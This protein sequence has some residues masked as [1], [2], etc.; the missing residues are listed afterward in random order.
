MKWY[1]NILILLFLPAGILH[2]QQ[3]T[4]N[5]DILF[6]ST[7]MKLAEMLEVV[8]DSTGYEFSFNPRKVPVDSTFLLPDLSLH[9]DEFLNLLEGY[10][11]NAEISGQHVILKRSRVMKAA[12]PSYFTLN[13]TLSDSASGEALIGASVIVTET[14][15]G[16]VTNGY[17]FFSLTLEK[18]KHEIMVSYVGYES[19]RESINLVSDMNIRR[20]L[21]QIKTELEEVE[22]VS[23]EFDRI[24]EVAGQGK[25]EMPVVSVRKMPG[26]LGETDVIK[27]LQSLPGISF[28]SDGSTIFHVRGGARDQNLLMIDE[29][30]VYNPAHLLGLFSVFTPDALNSINVYKGDMPAMYGGRLSSVID[31][32]MKEGNRNKLSFSGNTGPIA[33]T[34]NLEAPFLKKKGSFYLSGRRSHLKWIFT[35]SSPGLEELHFTDFNLKTN[36]RF[37]E[38]NRLYISFYSGIDKFRNR[39]RIL[40]SSGIS[41]FN[42]AGNIRWNTV[43]RNRIFINT[44]LIYSEYDYN[45]YTSY[46][47]NYRWNSNIGYAAI[48]SDLTYYIRPGSTLRFGILF[49]GHSYY[50]GNFLTGDKTD[51]LV[52]GVPEK[53]TAENGIYL[54]YELPLGDE[55]SMSY[56][57][58]LVKWS[59]RGPGYEFVYD[60]QDDVIDTL[61]YAGG[62]IYNS[63][64]SFEPRIRYSFRVQD[65]IRG[66]LSLGRNV[67]FEHLISNSISPFTSLEVWLPAGPNIKPVTADQA[68]AGLTWKF[69]RIR[70]YLDAEV[71]IKRMQNYISYVDHAYMLFNPQV[72]RELLYG[73]A[74][75][76]G[77]EFILKKTDGRWNG[78]ISYVWTRTLAKVSGINE[79]ME[80]PARY[81]RP[82][83]LSAY[84]FWQATGRTNLSA[85]WIFTSGSPFSTPTSYYYYNGYQVPYYGSRNNDR[86]PHYHRMDIGAEIRLNNPGS[87]QEH[88]LKFSVFNLYGRKNPFSINF[89]KILDENGN[90]IIPADYA[91]IP[92]FVPTMMYIYGMIPSISYHFKF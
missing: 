29:A 9:M 2:A 22:I 51:P 3:D 33:T 50:P 73:T 16:T 21:S 87:A 10:G 5:K 54:S 91:E 48:K 69:N 47:F 25:V 26:F 30:P 7:G 41:W 89:N 63:F 12:L 34:L 92:E 61:I 52:E 28:F 19:G 74:R 23:D 14:G 24:G 85:S 82:H 76:F 60:N 70:S 17:G 1:L 42:F 72:D 8:S 49:A 68:S 36:Y 84:I 20:E 66:K 67:Q 83:C 40:K 88:L 55:S 45:L 77:T 56:G 65:N 46:E 31:V 57:L 15:K 86:L 75:A 39:E 6:P 59:N 64:N 81:D 32:K 4:R 13:G 18:G 53:Y 11:L 62:N 38:R 58:R 78:W 35:R 71:F 80:F 43:I 37:N 90:I 27:S 79:G 44:S